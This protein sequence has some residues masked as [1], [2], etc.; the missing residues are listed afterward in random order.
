MSTRDQPNAR[1]IGLTMAE[2][3]RIADGTPAVLIVDEATTRLSG[4]LGR[5][6]SCGQ[7]EAQT[8][9]SG[10]GGVRRAALCRRMQ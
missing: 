3:A 1:P 8:E 7:T 6:A 4:A 2:I 5:S 10:A 9:G